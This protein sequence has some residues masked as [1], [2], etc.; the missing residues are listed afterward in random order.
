MDPLLTTEELGLQDR[1]DELPEEIME[2]IVGGSLDAVMFGIQETY[3]LTDDQSR[4]LENEIILV[5][6]FFASRNEFTANIQESLHLEYR[7]AEAISA[8]VSTELFELVE[9]ILDAVAEARGEAKYIVPPLSEPEVLEVVDKKTDLQKLAESFAEKSR[10]SQTATLQPI[11]LDEE[12]IA[13]APATPESAP[14]HT[15][16]LDTVQPLRTMQSDINRVHGYGATNDKQT[17]ETLV[18]SN[19]SDLLSRE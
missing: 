16:E 4:L 6:S 11:H 10:R 2:L 18:A 14:L 17:E 15:Q 13:P 1:F 19:Q 12:I 7:T 3:K 8:E 9:D 5:L